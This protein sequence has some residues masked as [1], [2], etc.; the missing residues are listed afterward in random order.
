MKY[1]KVYN[2]FIGYMNFIDYGFVLQ[3]LSWGIL[4]SFFMNISRLLLQ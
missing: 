3:L 2:C 1:E 4:V